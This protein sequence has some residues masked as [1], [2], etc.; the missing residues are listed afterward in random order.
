MATF[1][2]SRETL[3]KLDLYA[4]LLEEWQAKFNLVGPATLPHI[5]SRHFADSAQLLRLAAREGAAH[6][7]TWLDIGSG[8]GFPGMVIALM[9]GDSVTLVDSIRK[10]T[11]FLE[12]VRDALGLGQNV[13]VLNQRVESLGSVKFDYITARACAPLAKLFDWGEPYAAKSCTWLLLK[14]S[15]V[16]DEMGDARRRFVFEHELIPSLTDPRGR[17]VRAGNVRRRR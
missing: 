12:A 15:A 4:A 7:P 8:A 5:W 10:K 11:V 1:N 3:A 14:G 2:V 9:T 13:N 6:R 17:I 16:E